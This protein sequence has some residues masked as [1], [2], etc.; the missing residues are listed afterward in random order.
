MCQKKVAPLFQYTKE[1]TEELWLLGTWASPG[2]LRS[3]DYAVRRVLHMYIRDSFSC[4]ILGPGNFM[5]LHGF[6][7]FR[8]CHDVHQIPRNNRFHAD[9]DQPA[10]ILADVV[11]TV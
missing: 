11:L 3:R 5:I 9:N 1:I 10:P 6:P 8:E 2:I 4:M 7:R